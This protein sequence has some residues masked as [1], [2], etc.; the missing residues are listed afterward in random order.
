MHGLQIR[1]S[2]ERYM[3]GLQI[4]ASEERYMHGLQIRASG[5]PSNPPFGVAS[6]YVGA[7]SR[8]PACTYTML[9]SGSFAF[10]CGVA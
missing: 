7:K 6:R 2:E 4:R 9:R 5:S 8:L 1:A 3:H 10:S